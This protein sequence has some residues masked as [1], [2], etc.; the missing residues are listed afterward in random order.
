VTGKRQEL[1]L[2]EDSLTLDKAVKI[3]RAFEKSAKQ[4]KEFRDSAT[5]SNSST[6]VNKVTQ[7]PTPKLPSNQKPTNANR[8]SKKS[9]ERLKFDCKFC[10]NKHESQREKS[11]AWGKTCDNCEG[12]NHFKSKCKKVH[13]VSQS[14]DS[15]NDYDDQWLMA[16]NHGEESITATFSVNEHDVR[17][18][19]D[20]AADVN[21]ICQRHVWKHQVPPTSVRLNMWN[22]TNLKPLGETVLTIVN[23]PTPV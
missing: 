12:R 4:V 8:S 10:G 7:K 11:P 22:K 5:P 20:S 15:N 18:Q 3:C 17:F 9:D 16:V 1:L 21:T 2:S 14:Q 13:A 23:S 6:K 19:L